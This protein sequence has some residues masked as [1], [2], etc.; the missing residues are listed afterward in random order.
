[1]NTH[2]T[3][4]YRFVETRVS[5]MS[6]RWLVLCCVSIAAAPLTHAQTKMFKC[7]IDGRTVYQQTACPVSARADDVKPVAAAASANQLPAS[8][9]SARAGARA[10]APSASAGSNNAVNSR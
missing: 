3:P 5:Q 9:P 4:S 6:M 2:M 1:M 10:A 7:M 8:G